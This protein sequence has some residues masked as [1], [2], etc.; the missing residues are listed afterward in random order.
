MRPRPAPVKI[1]KKTIPL[2]KRIIYALDVADFKQ[3]K[4]WVDLL[5]PEVKFFKVGLQLFL[6]AGWQPIDYILDKGG[7]VMLDLKFLDI[8]AT[9]AKSVEQVIRQA[10]K[11]SLLT[12]HAHS[13]IIKAAADV[14]ENSDIKI[15][16]VTLLTSFGKQDMEEFTGDSGSVLTPAALVEKRAEVAL[17]AGADGLVAS[18]QEAA[19]LRAKYGNNFL[20]VTPGVRLD[21]NQN[22]ASDQIRIATP[23]QAVQAGADYL[24]IGRPISMAKDPVSRVQHIK[25]LL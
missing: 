14:C 21:D 16:A 23:Q 22:E 15:L 20:L 17:A 2:D 25:S 6:A 11:V 18:P 13:S 5:F 24:V 19:E 12:I 4:E 10:P 7:E 9:V 3:A 1:I 8:P